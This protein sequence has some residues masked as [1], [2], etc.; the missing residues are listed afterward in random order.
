MP[1][2]T[3]VRVKVVHAHIH[4]RTHKNTHCFQMVARMS[5]V[6]IVRMTK[7]NEHREVAVA[8]P[9]TSASLISNPTPPL[10]PA[11]DREHYHL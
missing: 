10:G 11:I 6:K 9:L 8:S 4:T 1:C 2:H 5:E 7:E 3:D